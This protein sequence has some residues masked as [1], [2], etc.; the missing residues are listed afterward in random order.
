MT[1]TTSIADSAA[2]AAA[3]A[4]ALYKQDDYIRTLRDLSEDGLQERLKATVALEKEAMK[5]WLDSGDCYII[6]LAGKVHLPT[7]QSMHRYV[8]RDAAWWGLIFRFPDKM[9]EW[10]DEDNLPPWPILKTRA[11]IEALPKYTA[12]PLCA[13]D[14]AH[15]NKPER[16]ITWTYLP[17]RS[18]K[19]KHFGTEFRLADGSRLGALTRI[20]TEETI[21][22]LVFSA[23]FSQAEAPIADPD[24]E[25]MYRTGMRALAATE[26]A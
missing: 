14:L 6:S 19:S 26:T 9:L 5:E 25:L 4:R 23:S 18:L 1:G 16:A 2:R 17:A 22:G 11:Q 15:L 12:C 3:A 8:D 21:D 20:T 7:C 13:P 24:M 10:P